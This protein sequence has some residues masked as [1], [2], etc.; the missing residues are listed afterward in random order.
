MARS[1]RLTIPAYSHHLIQRGNNRQPI[2]FAEKD[3]LYYLDCMQKAKNKCHCR[4]YS[5]VLMT[6]HVHLLIEPSHP[7]DLG[8][9]M[10]SVGRRYV[11]YINETYG[12]SG[13][14]WEGRYKSAVV[15]QDEY[16]I[17]CSRYIE[18]NAVRAGMV[19]HPGD[20]R[21]SSYGFHAFGNRNS[22]IDP[23]PW[24][25]CLGDTEEERQKNYRKWMESDVD[26]A[27]WEQ[28][29]QNTQ[30]GRVIGKERFQK[31]MEQ[32]AGRKLMGESRGRPRKA[33]LTS[34]KIV[35]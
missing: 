30:K 31:E 23:D 2:F 28:V 24:Y 19:E 25:Q 5:Y 20:Y 22:L 14:L 6:N 34:S 8:R 1:P 17:V 9:F 27:E 15:S 10:Q 12:R 29:R 26:P 33:L 11:R 35:L 16:L 21:W 13:T 4:L 7:G 32:R 18:F 3:Y